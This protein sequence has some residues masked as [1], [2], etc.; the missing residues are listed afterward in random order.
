MKLSTFVVMIVFSGL[1]L[2]YQWV[3]WMLTFDL[4]DEGR[5]IAVLLSAGV[6]WLLASALVKAVQGEVERK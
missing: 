6:L 1:F 4:N 3:D 5:Y 2:L